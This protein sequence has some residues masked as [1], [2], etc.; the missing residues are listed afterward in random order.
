MPI[1]V[2]PRPTMCRI[3]A[4]LGPPLTLGAFM[5]APQHSLYKQSWAA[6]ELL[7]AT[8]NADG[9]G[10]AWQAEDGC[11]AVYRNIMP[12]W[13]DPNLTHLERS[14]RSRVWLGNV[15]SATEGLATHLDNTQPYVAG[16][17]MF[18]HNGFI[19]DFPVNAR[20]QIRAEL[21]DNIEADIRGSTDSE[22]I[23]GL[24][25]QQRQSLD[26]SLRNVHAWLSSLLADKPVKALLNIIVSNGES[27]VAT[28][29][30]I[31]ASAPSLYFHNQHPALEH[32]QVI[33]S[34]PFDED[35]GWQPVPE[36]HLLQLTPGV[37]PAL[38]AL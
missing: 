11:P 13:A 27:L 31:N 6:R 18:I 10:L 22:Y 34:E 36:N 38:Q 4:Y 24:L 21:D 8:V 15:R 23:F 33:A 7:T 1:K 2:N 28:R 37:P 20:R 17:I 12:V 26:A 32:G 9:Y 35:T 29:S 16:Q 3:A 5:R 19:T 25:R 30:A 14:L